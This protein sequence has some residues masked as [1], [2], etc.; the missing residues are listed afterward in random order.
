MP[1]II[2]L[3]LRNLLHALALVRSTGQGAKRARHC[4]TAADT[5]RIP[6]TANTISL[7]TDIAVIHGVL[8]TS[9]ASAAPMPIVTNKAGR[10]Q[11]SSV[12]IEVNKLS[13]GKIV[14]RHSSGS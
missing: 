8:P 7:C 13:D 6:A 1:N 14:C 9:P 10:A 2:Q 11:Q 5:I 4:N 3:T 12:P